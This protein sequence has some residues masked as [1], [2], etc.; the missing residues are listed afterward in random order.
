MTVDDGRGGADRIDVVIA[1]TDTLEPPNAPDAPTVRPS[2]RGRLT[3]HWTA[4]NNAGRP[5]IT[6]YDIRYASGGSVEHWPH[7]VTDTQVTLAGLP[8]ATYEV[9]V[10]ARNDEG[11]SAWSAPGTGTAVSNTAPTVDPAKLP[12]LDATIGGATEVVPL[13]EAFSDLDGDPLTFSVASTNEA[14]VVAKLDGEDVTVEVGAA[15][16]ADV[17]VVAT[18][19]SGSSV[20]GTFKVTAHEPTLL[21]LELGYSPTI[22]TLHIELAD[23]FAANEKRAY[24]LRIRPKS[25]RG[26]SRRYC[27]TITN[28]FAV[29]G[30]VLTEFGIPI[31]TFVQPDTGYEVDYRY[32]GGDSCD[33][34]AVPSPWSRV[35]TVTT[36]T[37]GQGNFDIEVVFV[38]DEPSAHI[39]SLLEEA[40]R[41]WE[42]VITN[43]LIDVDFQVEPMLADSCFSGQ[44]EF[45]GTVDD[46]LVFARV[47]PGDG[48]GGNVGSGGVCRYRES[49]L[50]PAVGVV[51]L[52]TYDLAASD[53]L[54]KAIMRHEIAHAL[55]FGTSWRGHGLLANPSIVGG[56]KVSPTP[57]THFTG[58]NAVAAFDAAGGAD[59]QGAKVPVENEHGGFGSL[60]KHW[61][62]SVM[63][64]E[65]MASSLGAAHALSLI[66]IQSMADLGYSVDVDQADSF[67]LPT[68]SNLALDFSVGAR[69]LPRCVARPLTSATP[70]REAH[71]EVL[72]TSH[73]DVE[74]NV[75]VE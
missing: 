37:A 52:D 29:A 72:R 3:V 59:Y 18:D 63:G 61:R 55:G 14:I 32:L 56:E 30:I 57:D 60:D 7:T 27:V 12:D 41:T 39:K 35:S 11:A 31:G 8:A 17:S 70:V 2:G 62:K 26:E 51:S 53:S 49:S 22:K 67:T 1:V 40:V 64:T 33:T 68:P 65:L 75:T 58:T 42:S 47:A 13:D 74:V 16:A 19:P 54:A 50:L 43:D 71:P 28:P 69:E 9:Q 21:N 44:P 48:A 66:T 15:G 23:A 73:I 20:S 4:P 6:G 36:P 10:L 25:P 5:P 38:G 24:R 34:T 46:L 45:S